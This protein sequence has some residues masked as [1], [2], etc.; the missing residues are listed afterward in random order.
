[1]Q[2]HD[3][4]HM[5]VLGSTLFG[6]AGVA[7][8]VLVPLVFETAPHGFRRAKPLIASL[9]TLAAVLLLL[10]WLGVH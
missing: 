1:M 9:I 2:A 5:A 10:E 3:W 7:L 4:W 6:A 8:L